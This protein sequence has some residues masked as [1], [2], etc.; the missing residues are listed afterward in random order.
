VSAAGQLVIVFEGNNRR[1]DLPVRATLDRMCGTHGLNMRASPLT[2]E[3]DAT[4][5][6]TSAGPP[7]IKLRYAS[8]IIFIHFIALLACL[9]WFFSWTGV[10]LAALGQYVFG[11]IGRGMQWPRDTRKAIA[12][13]EN[14]KRRSLLPMSP[15]L[16]APASHC[17]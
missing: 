7:R 13:K 10:V 11:A 8:P 1:T 6:A 9:P 15:W 12:R 14:L 16:L 3:A 2:G 4:L 17:Y 5:A